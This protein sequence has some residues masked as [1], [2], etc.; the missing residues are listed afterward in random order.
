MDEDFFVYLTRDYKLLEV[1][2]RGNLI[3][4]LERTDADQVNK[5]YTYS[6]GSRE[7]ILDFS[8]NLLP[9]KMD[10]EYD[11]S[12]TY[13]GKRFSNPTVQLVTRPTSSAPTTW[14]GTCWCALCT[15]H[16]FR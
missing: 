3:G 11:F 13:Q 2:R 9:G 7:V 8:Y 16:G 14:A 6:D 10:S 1:S 15:V 4:R 12:L 5:V